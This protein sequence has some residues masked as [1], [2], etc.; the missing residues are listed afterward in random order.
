VRIAV[1]GGNG[2]LGRAVVAAA[3]AAGHEALSLDRATGETRQGP[4]QHHTDAL[5]VTDYDAFVAKIDGCDALV[6][7]AAMASPHQAPP[8]TVHANNV[9]GNYHALLAA[10]QVG[11]RRVV[12]ASSINAIGGHY[13]RWPRYDY[14]PL[15][16]DHPTYAEDPY[17]LSKWLG[18]QQADA[19]CRL[20][21]N[22]TVA[23]LRFHWIVPQSPSW[24]A[25]DE[26]ALQ[27]HAKHLWGWTAHDAAVRSCLL[28]LSAG[29][30]G[31]EAFFIVA[32]TTASSVSSAELHA[33]Y[34]PDVPVRRPLPAAAG[35][36]D[37]SK[38]TKLLGWTHDD[39]A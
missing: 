22:M 14:L 21:E 28:G 13:S 12:T 31:H 15:D 29:Y 37:C 24:G 17:S 8:Q 2:R 10:A 30:T 38:A 9:L 32:P 11:I 6:H 18:E 35:F 20:H 7:L 26:Q 33:R 3:E 34:H 1:T 23:S 25:A 36:Y 4:A 16:E 19:I 5:D 27:T 39:T